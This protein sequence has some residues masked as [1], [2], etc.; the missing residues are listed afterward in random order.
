MGSIIL[1]IYVQWFLHHIFNELTVCLIL[2]EDCLH[3]PHLRLNQMCKIQNVHVLTEH[4]IMQ[5]YPNKL[6][7]IKNSNSFLYSVRNC[8]IF[9]SQSRILKFWVF[10]SLWK[11]VNNIDEINQNWIGNCPMQFCPKILI[12]IK[13]NIFI[14]LATNF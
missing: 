2:R 12:Y 11:I 5:C 8:L 13:T 4:W 1:F 3:F 10:F 6:I 9:F 7:Y 14:H